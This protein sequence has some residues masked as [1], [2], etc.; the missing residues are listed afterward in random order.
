MG[1]STISIGCI[2]SCKLS[3]FI[4]LE[5]FTYEFNIEEVENIDAADNAIVVNIDK[6]FFH[7]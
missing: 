5:F 3:T 6:F 1:Y 7:K 2:I 4:K